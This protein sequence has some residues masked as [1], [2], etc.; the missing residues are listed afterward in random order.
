MPTRLPPQSQS[1]V[2]LTSS[3]VGPG[4]RRPCTRYPC[5]RRS[6]TLPRLTQAAQWPPS[7]ERPPEAPTTSHSVTRRLL[8]STLC[9]VMNSLLSRPVEY[10][11]R[12]HSNGTCLALRQKD[13]EFS[14]PPFSVFSQLRRFT[15]TEWDGRGRLVFL[16]QF[17]L[18]G[19]FIVCIAS[20]V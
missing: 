1:F 3:L 8:F 2:P 5:G 18:L 11:F 7:R 17:D 6:G 9:F 4:V 19:P 13:G 20:F 12:R 16:V 10:P 14:Q 15:F